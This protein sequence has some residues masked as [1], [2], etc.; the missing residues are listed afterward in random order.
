VG[1]GCCSGN[2]I[3]SKVLLEIDDLADFT[4]YEWAIL[5]GCFCGGGTRA[6]AS[7]ACRLIDD[8]QKLGKQATISPTQYHCDIHVAQT[9][10]VAE[11]RK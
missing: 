6:S 9:T 8:N 11:I 5:R 10:F 3:I 7:R 4:R 1:C 2:K